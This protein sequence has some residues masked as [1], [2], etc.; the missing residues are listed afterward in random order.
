MEATTGQCLKD[1]ALAWRRIVGSLKGGKTGFLIII[2]VGENT[3]AFF[4]LSGNLS[5]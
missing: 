3:H 1:C 5:P 4:F 2:R